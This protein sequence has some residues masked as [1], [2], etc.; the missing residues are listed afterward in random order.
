MSLC[1]VRLKRTGGGGE[2]AYY[3]CSSDDGGYHN[4]ATFD[5]NDERR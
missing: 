1:S 2:A 5:Y 4:E 3:D